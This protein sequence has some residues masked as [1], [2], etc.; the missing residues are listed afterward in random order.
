MEALKGHTEQFRPQAVGQRSP[1]EGVHN[2]W[3]T[4]KNIKMPIDI[5]L[6]LL[7]ACFIY[8]KL[9]SSE[10]LSNSPKATQL[11]SMSDSKAVLF[12]FA[13]SYAER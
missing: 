12:P 13:E 5:Y 9:L 4:G 1:K 8:I 3:G 6:T 11:V 7:T 2:Y 10:R